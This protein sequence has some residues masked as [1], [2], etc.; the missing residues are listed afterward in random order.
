MQIGLQA[1]GC[2]Y[3]EAQCMPR[4]SGYPIIDICPKVEN[5][6]ALVMRDAQLDGE[7]G[8]FFNNYGALFHG[9]DEEVLVVLASENP[10]EKLDQSGPADWGFLIVPRAVGGNSHID[11]AAKRRIPALNGR[12]SVTSLRQRRRRSFEVALP[13]LSHCFPTLLDLFGPL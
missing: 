8:N 9:G 13:C 6:P 10:S 3:L 1:A 2:G 11:I 7:E 5:V 12:Q 4:A